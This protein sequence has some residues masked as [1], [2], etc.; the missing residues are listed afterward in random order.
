M[1]IMLCI[2]A[3]SVVML[4]FSSEF[5]VDV[6]TPEENSGD[7]LLDALA[8]TRVI[9]Y[10]SL[11]QVQ[12]SFEKIMGNTIDSEIFLINSSCYYYDG[13]NYYKNDNCSIQI[14]ST[15]NVYTGKVVSETGEI[16]K[17]NYWSRI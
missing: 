17:I 10:T 7:Y 3:F 13:I 14:N 12:N 5:N 9:N 6:Q 2:V 1:E 8:K 11:L 4:Y 15:K 16:I